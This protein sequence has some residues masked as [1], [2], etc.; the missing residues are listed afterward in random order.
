MENVTRLN[1][2]TTLTVFMLPTTPGDYSVWVA[3]VSEAGQGEFSDR[4]GFEYSSN[5]TCTT[6]LHCIQYTDMHT[7][8]ASYYRIMYNIMSIKLVVSL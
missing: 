4:E 7:K 5:F 3:A 2:T 1:T 6:C 8:S